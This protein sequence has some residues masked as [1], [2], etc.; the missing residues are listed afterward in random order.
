VVSGFAA[1][2]DAGTPVW[3]GDP[4]TFAMVHMASRPSGVGVLLCSPFGWDEVSSYRPRYEWAEQLA[5]AGFPT[6]R[7]D[8]P[9]TGDSAGAP[10]DPHRLAA[11]CQAVSDIATHLRIA[12]GVSI[13]TAI[14]VGLGGLIAIEAVRR[15]AP[16]SDVALWGSP[17]NGREFVRGERAFASMQDAQ[18]GGQDDLLLS[19][20]WVQS[21]GFVLS[22]EMAD[23]LRGVDVAS[24]AEG[25]RRVLLLD[26]DGLAMPDD[27]VQALRSTGVEVSQASGKG[28]GLF[29]HR[30]EMAELP[31]GVVVGL[32]QWL[33]ETRP[34]SEAAPV[35]AAP[36]SAEELRL[37]HGYERVVQIP[38]AEGRPFAVVTTPD[39]PRPGA[40]TLVLL[41]AWAMR[42]SGPNR[43]WTEVARLAG[44]EGFTTVRVDL[45]G[46]GDADG[47][48][49]WLRFHGNATD[50]R[51][52]GE[53]RQ[54]LDGLVAAGIGHSFVACG[55]SSGGFWAFKSM[56]E[57]SRIG[58]AVVMNAN[59]HLLEPSWYGALVRRKARA[60]LYPRSWMRI[61]RGEVDL[62]QT[63]VFGYLRQRVI[64]PRSPTIGTPDPISFLEALDRFG[65]RAAQLTLA[66]SANEEMPPELQRRGLWAQLSGRPGVM[67]ENIAGLDHNLRSLAA[68]RDVHRIVLEHL[69]RVAAAPA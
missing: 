50:P 63:K 49:D 24:G 19:Q 58:S 65:G 28:Y 9:G 32:N 35:T 39:I 43:M 62:R 59:A 12:T 11:W 3:I 44:V 31:V 33:A 15:G 64:R 56:L 26:R 41:P 69:R 37:A 10:S 29:V 1:R 36:V 67:L 34:A 6:V 54:I 30:A 7:F 16:V 47:S 4:P 38:L 5:A 60:V 46:I 20:G 48:R 27:V 53:I 61:V 25:L 66:F 45:S 18:R 14:G 57:D 42:R 23:D 8:W 40:P 52:I 68:Q 13:V 2:S 22:A 21:G 55:M 17:R 51:I